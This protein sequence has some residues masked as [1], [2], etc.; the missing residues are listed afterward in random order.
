[1]NRRTHG[2]VMLFG[3]AAAVFLA[4]RVTKLWAEDALADGP[5][6]VIEGVLRL[7][8]TTN[9]GGAFSLFTDTP[10]LFV[11]ASVVVTAAVI[12]TAFR[13]R[14]ALQSVALGLIL[15]GAIGNLTD[16]ATRG[17]GFTGDVVDFI[18]LH[19]WPVFN[20]ADS[21]IV[22]GAIALAI[23]SF[24]E[25]RKEREATEEPVDR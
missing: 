15:G 9:T 12:A 23:S 7:R 2:A 13:E 25:P 5:V 8:F 6:E 21:A 16:R 11:T 3:T 4:D 10:W 1:M 19:V 24:L 18:D 22:V 14:P 20:L 17:S